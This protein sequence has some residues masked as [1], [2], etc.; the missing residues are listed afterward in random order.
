MAKHNPVTGQ[1]R[2]RRGRPALEPGV[3]SVNLHVRLT[4]AQYDLTCQQATA[5]RVPLSTWVRR[6][7]RA[8]GPDR[9]SS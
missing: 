1:D 3:P 2:R 9:S 7:L 6:V 4:S 8:A 5:A